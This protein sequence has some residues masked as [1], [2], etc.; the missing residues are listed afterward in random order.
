[1]SAHVFEHSFKSHLTKKQSFEYF[2]ELS[3]RHSL[4]RP[5]H[6]VCIFEYEELKQIS[7]YWL[8]TFHRFYN[9]Y[10]ECFMTEEN[11]MLISSISGFSPF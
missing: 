7:K 4:F 6:S 10:A 11:E 5:P 8:D 2:T 9:E 3:V 1:M